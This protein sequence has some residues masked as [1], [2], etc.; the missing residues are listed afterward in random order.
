MSVGNHGLWGWK[1]C[2]Q[3]ECR[4]VDGVELDDV[5]ADNVEVGR[6]QVILRVL[7]G[8][9]SHGQIICKGIKPDVDGVICI[10]RDRDPPLDLMAKNEE[11]KKQF[12]LENRESETQK[13]PGGKSTFDESLETERSCISFFTMFRRKLVLDFG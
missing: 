2:G 7:P 4:P 13:A 10:T 1:T 8:V 9:A 3:K 5:L 6:P 12:W 11:K